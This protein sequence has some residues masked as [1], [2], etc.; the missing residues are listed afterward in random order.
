MLSVTVKS[1][2]EE[3]VIFLLELKYAGLLSML[4]ELPTEMKETVLLVHCPY[5]LFPFVRGIVAD[6]TR[7]GGYQPLL[8]EPVDFASLYL[9]K[10]KSETG[11]IHRDD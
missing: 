4:K 5:L 11:G 9:E 7:A 8:I 3:Q 6:I 1:S 2:L 10:R